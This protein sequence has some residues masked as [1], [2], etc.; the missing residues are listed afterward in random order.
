[1]RALIQTTKKSMGIFSL[2][3]GRFK[4]DTVLEKVNYAQS[5]IPLYICVCVH[6]RASVCACACVCVCGW[7]MDGECVYIYE[8]TIIHI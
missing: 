4:F 2:F 7:V 1:M 6:T 3:V 5:K 8:Y